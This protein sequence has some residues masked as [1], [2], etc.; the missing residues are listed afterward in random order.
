[1]VPWRMDTESYVASLRRAFDAPAIDPSG[2]PATPWAPDLADM[3]R[4]HGQAAYEETLLDQ[5]LRDLK[6]GHPAGSQLGP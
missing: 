5:L 3:I 6:H 4:R 1:M 2:I